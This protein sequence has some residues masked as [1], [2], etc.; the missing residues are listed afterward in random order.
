[1]AVQDGS[2]SGNGPVWTPEQLAAIEAR[3]GEAVVVAG[4]GSG[5][6]GVLAEAVALSVVKDDVAADKVLAITFTRKAAAEMRER[7]RSRTLK[8]IQQR[9]RLDAPP[10]IPDQEPEVST[11]DAFCQ[12]MVRRNA[13]ELGIDPRFEIVDDADPALTSRAWAAALSNFIS[14]HGKVAL[15]LLAKYDDNPRAPL[16]ANI[17]SVHARLRTGG[18]RS[19]RLEIPDSAEM[20]A[21]VASALSSAQALARSLIDSADGWDRSKKSVAASLELAASLVELDLSKAELAPRRIIDRRVKEMKENELAESLEAALSELNSATTDR[22]ALPDLQLFADLLEA[23]D[24]EY[25]QMKSEAG[26]LDF[27][28][29]A[30][31]SRDLLVARRDSAQGSPDWQPA[32]ARFERVF[33]DEAQDVNRVQ[34]ELIDLISD[35]SGYFSVGDAAQSIYRF[36]HADVEIFEERAERL[37]KAGR[38]LEL[39]T[40]FR[41]VSTILDANNQIFSSKRLRGMIELGAH[42]ANLVDEPRIELILEEADAVKERLADE[43]DPPQWLSEVVDS[44]WRYAEAAAV[45]ARIERLISEGEAATGEITILARAVSGLVPFAEALRS[46]GIPATIEGAGGLW[47]RPEVSDLVALLAATGN[48]CD[49]AQLL[50]LLHSPVCRLSVDA[51]VLVAAAAKAEGVELLD[52]LRTVELPAADAAR[53]E[54][55]VPWFDRQRA[56]AG[57]RSLSDAIEAALVETGLDLHLLGLPAGDR[58]FANVRRMQALAAVWEAENGSDPAGF[59]REAVSRLASGD[60]RRDGEA[61]VEQSGESSG[62]VRLMTIHQ[63]KGLEFPVTVF[64]DLGRGSTNDAATLNV[65]ADGSKMVFRWRSAIGTKAL[66]AFADP[67]FVASE[68][69]AD[70]EEEIRV[71]YVGATRAQRLLIMSGSFAGSLKEKPEP[72]GAGGTSNLQRMIE[73]GLLAGLDSYCAGRDTSAWT[74][75]YPNGSSIRVSVDVGDALDASVSSRPAIE[76][77]QGEVDLM[78][79]PGALDPKPVPLRPTVLSYSGLQTA[80][81]CAFRWYAENVIE[82]SPVAEAREAASSQSGALRANE[83]GTLLHGVLERTP[84][85]GSAPLL[86]DARSEADL[87]DIDLAAGDGEMVTALAGAVVDSD[88]WRRLISLSANGRRVAREEGF[89]VPLICQSLL[90]PLRGV[91]D[92]F[93]LESDDAAVVVDWKT[94]DG[95]VD[96]DDIEALVQSEYS[97]QREAY[98]FA[99]LSGVFSGRRLSTVEVIHLYAESP[100]EP[101]VARFTQSDLEGLA[102]SLSARAAPLLA[103]EVPVTDRPWISICSGCPA[104]GRL[105]HWD[106]E[107]TDSPKPPA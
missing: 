34:A 21:R 47:L 9:D 104:R 29:L 1:M 45:A 38:R 58:R 36:R 97:I 17:G 72:K 94:S 31:L 15:S 80:S 53:R 71:A 61:V 85:D 7:I 63:A 99:A 98:A 105:C 33:L 44:G 67:D 22:S 106:R 73:A 76:P 16:Q 84:L 3:G 14:S 5:K 25:S 6:T 4:A 100:G 68:K 88:V 89:T 37:D 59:A 56:L 8:L 24:V 57:R 54:R 93:A 107:A 41:S 11:I 82:L 86:V 60:N 30:L 83:R 87:R 32:G 2:M 66:A 46:R 91:F 13:L 39:S 70:V 28:D 101:A 62:A 43:S 69:Q 65:S 55:F 18:A 52:A 48:A 95:A 23:Y 90:V 12:G 50:Q 92:V 102:E 19:P 40:N 79:E 96:A 103:G 26:M 49:E 51:L 81:R 78:P 27:S 10:Q 75:E 74:E 20:E 42:D 35:G 77:P 64:V